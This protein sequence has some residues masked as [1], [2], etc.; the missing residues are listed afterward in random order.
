MYAAQPS[1]RVIAASEYGGDGRQHAADIGRAGQAG[2]R[3]P[4]WSAP[5]SLEPAMSANHRAA[6]AHERLARTQ[7]YFGHYQH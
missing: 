5:A 6:I 3:R 7:V 2:R 1:T 4:Q